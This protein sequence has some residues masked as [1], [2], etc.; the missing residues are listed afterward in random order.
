MEERERERERER[1]KIRAQT[2]FESK[3]KIS[4]ALLANG[5]SDKFYVSI[6]N[7]ALFKD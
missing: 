1:E 7:I 2:I 4:V 3:D 6:N 5:T